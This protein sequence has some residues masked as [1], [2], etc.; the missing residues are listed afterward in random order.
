MILYNKEIWDCC[1]CYCKR[2]WYKNIKN[3]PLYFKRLHFL[4]KNGY[5]ESAT[6]GIDDWFFEVIPSI[7]EKFKESTNGFPQTV[8]DITYN[9]KNEEEMVCEWHRVLDRMIYLSKTI[10][11]N[12]YEASRLTEPLETEFFKLF[13]RYFHSLWD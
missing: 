13:L 2:Y 1:F 5:N 6:W 12:F 8:E 7:L 10:H 4:I 11:E 3:I 9:E